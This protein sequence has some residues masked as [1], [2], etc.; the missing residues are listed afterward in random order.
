[1]VLPK[2]CAGLVDLLQQQ[3]LI[4]NQLR[5]TVINTIA[6]NQPPALLV[7]AVTAA[8]S[9]QAEAISI[10]L[11]AVRG[12]EV[13]VR[14]AELQKLQGSLAV[15]KRQEDA[16]QVLQAGMRG[17]EVRQQAAELTDGVQLR[18][19]CAVQAGIRGVWAR[20]DCEILWQRQQRCEQAVCAV[21]AGMRG[22]EAR[23]QAEV[24]RDKI[25]QQA[26]CAV[27]AC[28]VVKQ[29]VYSVA[30]LRMVLHVLE[31]QLAQLLSSSI[32]ASLRFWRKSF[33]LDVRRAQVQTRGANYM[34]TW[35]AGVYGNRVAQLEAELAEQT[36]AAD[37]AISRLVQLEVDSCCNSPAANQPSLLEQICCSPLA[38]RQMRAAL[39]SCWGVV[40]T[41]VSIWRSGWLGSLVEQVFKLPAVGVLPMDSL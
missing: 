1:M 14:V 37:E 32:R 33:L 24:L 17:A 23:Q 35:A 41:C 16:A 30:L 21:Q 10:I 40:S 11:A 22:A 26:V 2:G 25:Q 9:G 3:T 28:P 20:E 5:R 34:E 4:Q 7:P 39:P 31:R 19:V 15:L 38:A 12:S 18:A 29:V 8:G 36:C 6:Q 27:Q 13:R